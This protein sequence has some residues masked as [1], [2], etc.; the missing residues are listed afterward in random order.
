M[1]RPSPSLNTLAII[2]ARGG[3]KDIPRKNLRP[4]AG[5]PLISY[6]IRA[7]LSSHRVDHVAVSTD[8]PEIALFAER[9][10]AL[11]LMRPA[12]LADDVTTLDP[13]IEFACQQAEESMQL[14]FDVILTVQATS[15]LVIA[16]DID[17]AIGFFESEAIDTVIS[18]V[19]DRHLTWSV[20]G[21]VARPNYAGRVNRQQMPANFRETGAIIA[22]RRQLLK[23]GTR[24]GKNV[25]LHPLPKQRSVDIDTIH[26]IHVCEALI[27]ARTIV[28]AVAGH[29]S[30]GLGHAYRA[31]LLAHELVRYSILF[32][33]EATEIL[34]IAHIRKYNFTVEV[35]EPG[36]LA[37]TVI[38]LEPDLVIND[39]L[40]TDPA[41]MSTVSESGIPTVNFEDMGPSSHLASLT[42]NALYP[43][44][45]GQ[46][47]L[48]TGAD[49]FCLRDEFLYIEQRPFTASLDEVLLTFGGVDEGNLSTRVL[50][51]LAGLL[52]HSTEVTVV[53]GPGFAHRDAL[54]AMVGDLPGLRINIVAAT[55][56][57]SDY[58]NRCDLAITSAGRTVYEL[59]SLAR[60]TLVICQNERETTH[61]FASEANGIIN[62]GLRHELD[63]S[64][65]REQLQRL[66]TQ[67]DLRQRCHE[68]LAAINL[69]NGKKRVLRR[70]LD[71][72]GE[73]P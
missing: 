18:V 13:V 17:Q 70:I 39:I 6:A 43:Q 9:F 47:N 44:Q 69:R 22:C 68:K 1:D 33:C 60:P 28:F 46:P 63:D 4:I 73:S 55:A 3:S 62:L 11:V 57:I 25:K 24:I 58:M 48:L 72:I 52:D 20:E 32:V 56:R 8:D 5:K 10:G 15:P 71:L 30:I 35:C 12:A 31:L 65:L 59:A 19:D 64:V 51:V 41:Y 50:R 66:V 67:P 40:D 2:P 23:S 54:E 45:G 34:A 16:H 49:Y 36:E 29:D 21:G 38:G 42:I 53:L 14:S 26:D 61:H 37:E 27:R 7:C